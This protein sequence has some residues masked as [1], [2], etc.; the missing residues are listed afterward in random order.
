MFNEAP[1]LRY[2]H[3][4]NSIYYIGTQVRVGRYPGRKFVENEHRY[5]LQKASVF[6]LPT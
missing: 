6:C 2:L 4:N 3:T 1:L 5:L